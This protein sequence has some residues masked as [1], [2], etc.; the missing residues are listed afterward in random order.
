[1]FLKPLRICVVRLFREAYFLHRKVHG[2]LHADADGDAMRQTT[3][4][5]DGVAEGVA[6]IE[7][8]SD[9][10]VIGVGF[11]HTGFDAGNLF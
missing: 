7:Y 10:M 11:H 1:M 5:L 2:G 9:T 8:L 6:E 3:V 4:D